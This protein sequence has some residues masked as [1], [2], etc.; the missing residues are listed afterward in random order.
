MY[1]RT[2]V[3]LPAP[4][5]FWASPLDSLVLAA[6]ALAGSR[7]L[8]SLAARRGSER[9]SLG[10]SPIP[11]PVFALVQHGWTL[12]VSSSSR[13]PPGLACGRRRFLDLT[14]FGGAPL[15]SPHHWR[16]A[17]SDGRSRRASSRCPP[18]R[19]CGR[20]RF[21]CFA[22]CEPTLYASSGDPRHVRASAGLSRGRPER[23]PEGRVA[24]PSSEE[25]NP[26]MVRIFC[27]SLIPRPRPRP[28]PP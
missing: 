15:D 23:G 13:C 11:P 7:S 9:T 5:P 8:R 22:R 10:G 3:Q 18:G 26:T 27:C 4:P 21:P 24:G 25:I 6:L 14:S 19:A 28:G 16:A 1:F 12:R 20:G 17:R 2:R